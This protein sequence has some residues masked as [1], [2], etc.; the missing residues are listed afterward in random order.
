MALVILPLPVNLEIQR[1]RLWVPTHSPWPFLYTMFFT[2]TE[3]ITSHIGRAFYCRWQELNRTS[4]HPGRFHLLLFPTKNKISLDRIINYTCVVSAHVC[5]LQLET[6]Y[7]QSAVS[8]GSQYC[9]SIEVTL[10]NFDGG[11][12]LKKFMM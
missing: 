10:L 5:L 8:T 6:H 4:H 2:I 7:I 12:S 11:S 3:M 1:S 9:S